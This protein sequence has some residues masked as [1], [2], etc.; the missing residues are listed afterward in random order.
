MPLNRNSNGIRRKGKSI[1]EVMNFEDL[2][3]IH[4]NDNLDQKLL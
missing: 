1:A 2:P 3:E 4:T